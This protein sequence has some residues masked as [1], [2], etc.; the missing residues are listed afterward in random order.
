MYIDTTFPPPEHRLAQVM[1][2]FEALDRDTLAAVIERGI[3][4]LDTLDGDSDF[5]DG[6]D[7]EHVT[8][9]DGFWRSEWIKTTSDDHEPDADAQGDRAWIEWHGRTPAGQRRLHEP[10]G[11]VCESEDDEAD[12]EDNCVAGDDGCAPFVEQYTGKTVWGS[13]HDHNGLPWV[14][15]TLGYAHAAANEA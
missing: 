6:H 7:A 2:V 11:G 15:P 4:R 1:R 5:E 10:T 3:D 14:P 8:A 12:D 9:L 13:E